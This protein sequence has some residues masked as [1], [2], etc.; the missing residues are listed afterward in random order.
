MKKF[1]LLI[2]VIIIATLLSGC[3]FIPNKL[4]NKQ[5]NDNVIFAISD[6]N[7]Q[8][9]AD[10]EFKKAEQESEWD[11]QITDN[12]VYLSVMAY[13]SIDLNE[14]QSP[15]DAYDAQN[16]ELFEK[17]DNVSVIIKKNTEISEDK[18]II[19][20]RYSAES[21]VGKNYYDSFLVNFPEKETFAWIL[22][23]GVPSVIEN[24]TEKVEDMVFS[25]AVVE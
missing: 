5:E 1:K 18:I 19:H 20:T 10:S 25:L 17:R 13:K 8:L 3:A 6:Y 23:S 7:M 4:A 16:K 2:S 24:Y 11:L 14:N 15:E 9:T 12:N 21:E 22:V